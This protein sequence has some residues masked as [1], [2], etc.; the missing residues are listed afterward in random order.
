MI[1]NNKGEEGKDF[2]PDKGSDSADCPH[3]FF[4]M[5]LT[6]KGPLGRVPRS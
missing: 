1:R 3:I 6:E 5:P 2:V 4:A